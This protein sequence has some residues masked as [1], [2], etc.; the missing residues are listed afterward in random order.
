M[1]WSGE[2][3]KN[4]GVENSIADVEVTADQDARVTLRGRL[5][6]DRIAAN[7][8]RVVEPLRKA[9]APAISIDASGVDYCDGAGVGLLIELRRIAAR[10]GGRTTIHGLSEELAALVEL[11]S[12]DD[13]AARA[14]DP[15]PPAPILARIGRSASGYLRDTLQMIAFAGEATAALG[16]ALLH[17][18]QVRWRDVRTVA[19]KAGV[20]ALPVAALLGALVGAIVAYQTAAPLRN[21][22]ADADVYVA[23]IIAVAVLR[24]LGPLITAILAAGRT[25]S[26]FAAE[27]GTMKVTEELHALATMGLS[28]VRFLIV[29]RVLATVLVLPFL[30][31]FLNL[32]SVAGGYAVFAS[33]G[34]PLA[35]FCRRTLEVVNYVDLL[36]GLFKVVVFALLVAAVGCQRGLVTKQGPGAVGDSTTRAVV[37][38]IVLIIAADFLLG[39]AYFHLGI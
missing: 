7:W 35:T 16:W 14:L 26:A 38:G 21:F 4:Q 2:A 10:N 11:A 36:G 39:A 9:R 23:D 29:P 31:M 1:G 32:I 13:P 8:G 19:E 30:C 17:P 20:N 33:L 12:L 15:P 22:G 37:T 24:E 28:P 25:G 34:Y 27:V 5:D 18:R 3:M 6:A